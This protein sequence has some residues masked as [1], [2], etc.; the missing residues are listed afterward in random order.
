M[1]RPQNRFR[2]K[3]KVKV[4]GS[5]VD[6]KKYFENY[7]SHKKKEHIWCQNSQNDPKIKTKSNVRNER[8]KKLLHCMSRPQNNVLT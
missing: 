4:E 7:P 6:H 8:G 1:S 2:S 3:T 5:T